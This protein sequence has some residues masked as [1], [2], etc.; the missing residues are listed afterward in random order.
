MDG[1]QLMLRCK[2]EFKMNPRQHTETQTEAYSSSKGDCISEEHLGDMTNIQL[3]KTLCRFR[4]GSHWLKCTTIFTASDTKASASLP[5]L[6]C[7]A[8]SWEV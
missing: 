7:M 6:A 5:Q 2:A 3:R 8:A 4:C 1:F